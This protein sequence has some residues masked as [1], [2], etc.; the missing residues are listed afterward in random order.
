MIKLKRGRGVAFY[1]SNHCF[2]ESFQSFG[3]GGRRKGA[4][5]FSEGSSV[6]TIVQE[7]DP[8]FLVSHKSGRGQDKIGG[9]APS[10][11]ATTGVTLSLKCWASATPEEPLR[12]MCCYP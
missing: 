6:L 4:R 9:N 3:G 7:N 5:N 2:G 12:I 8:F 10:P 11:G 1:H